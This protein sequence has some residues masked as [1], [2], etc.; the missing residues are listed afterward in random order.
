SVSQGTLRITRADALG[1]GTIT[2]SGGALDLGSDTGLNVPLNVTLT[3]GS[4]INPGRA[5]SGAGLTHTFSGTL[6]PSFNTLTVNPGANVAVDTNFGLTFGA[7]TMTSSPTFN[8]A[9]NG[10]GI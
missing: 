7:V 5:T 4:Q 10:A 1:S 2:M 9:N 8:V 6:S 3:S